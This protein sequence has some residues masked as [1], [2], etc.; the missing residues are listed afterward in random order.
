MRAR[1]SRQ[2]LFPKNSLVGITVTSNA[3][4]ALRQF[5]DEIRQKALRSAAHAGAEVMYAEMRLRVPVDE[6][7]L[8]GSIY[9]WHDENRSGFNRQVY[10]VGPNKKKA[11]HWHL[12]EYG[13][14][15]VNVVIRDG[16]RWI[17]TKERLP[18]PKWVPAVPYA[19]P[20][21]DSKA[22]VA[23]EAMKL[24]LAA[25]IEEIKAEMA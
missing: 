7:T 12:L 4:A 8:Y 9:Q 6:G 15:R 5:A 17:A 13:H 18:Q 14:W 21:F 1:A 25:R 19:R 20:T 10:V 11:P 22:A 24:R 23:V 2:Q 3:G 16:S